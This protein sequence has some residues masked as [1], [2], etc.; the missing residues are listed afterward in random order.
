MTTVIQTV[1]NEDPPP[2]S[3]LNPRLS[4]TWDAVLQ[5]ALAKKPE[6]RYA[7]ARAMAEA[8]REALARERDDTTQVLPAAAPVTTTAAAPVP[9]RS[10]SRAW[11]IGAGLLAV[12]AAGAALQFR[13]RTAEPMPGPAASAA[14][15]PVVVAQSPPATAPAAAAAAPA[16]PA[17]AP[18]ATPAPAPAV[19]QPPQ[20]MPAASAP[21]RTTT[22]AAT[23][24]APSSSPAPARARAPAAAPPPAAASPPAATSPADEWVRRAARL[25]SAREV[26]QLGAALALLLGPVSA[27]E[28]AV[29]DEFDA[30]LRTRPPHAALVVGAAASGHAVYAW[31]SR[32]S[33]A[34][35]A[36]DAA[37]R[38]C[39]EQWSA[40]CRPVL[41]DGRFQR[42]GLAAAAREFT[43][44]VA[45]VRA[46]VLPHLVT[47]TQR[48]RRE[49]AA[50]AAGAAVSTPAAAA[51][52]PGPATA[53]A[54]SA[55]KAAAG[56]AP[57][58][59]RLRS[60]P[61][62]TSFAQ[63]LALLLDVQASEDRALLDRLQAR[64]LKLRWHSAV[65]LGDRDGW[66]GF[67][68]GQ[69]ER[70]AQWAAQEAL[71]RCRRSGAARCVIVHAN[72]Q[73]QR[74]GLIEFAA[75]LD[76]RPPAQV[77][78]AFLRWLRKWLA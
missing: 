63:A 78:E 45:T 46:A 6:Q 40:N 60:A 24:P 11:L 57:A 71:A 76:R 7:S 75:G 23:P 58:V 8:L 19:A 22:A 52:P 26:T 51:V 67:H 59:A 72:D 9:S 38:H 65:A 64:V 69:G 43:M 53:A 37:R 54:P 50:R 16:A 73:F 66:L 18:A 32:Q 17:P 68:P 33:S 14:A 56:W 44:P 41:V 5:R 3:Q 2:P 20:P 36:V 28:R 77:R 48:L 4:P 27:E 10:G 55:A 1:L 12:L 29:I 47:S 70:T 39:R 74:A 13:P 34:E 62:S 42:D 15:A 30:A 49:D 21:P 61:A 25:Q 31:R 35:A